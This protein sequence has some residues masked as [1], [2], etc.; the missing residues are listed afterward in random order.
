MESIIIEDIFMPKVI[1]LLNINND[2]ILLNRIF[3][4]FED[5]ANCGEEHVINLFTIT[6]LE[7]LGNDK[8]ILDTAIKYMG[9]K[10]K[11]LQIK[12][13]TDLGRIK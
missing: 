7:V 1:E 13:D 6:V 2:L 4:Y 9:P 3:D 10:T 11:Q 5:V 12:A 8:S